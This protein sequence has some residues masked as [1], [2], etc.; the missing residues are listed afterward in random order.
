[1]RETASA[2]DAALLGLLDYLPPADARARHREEALQ[3]EERNERLIGGGRAGEAGGGW[4][5]AS[6]AAIKLLEA[7]T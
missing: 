5:A 1:M 6:T 3:V 2:A 7:Q 4:F